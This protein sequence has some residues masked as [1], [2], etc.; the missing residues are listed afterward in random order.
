MKTY[1]QRRATVQQSIILASSTLIGG[2]FSTYFA[3]ATASRY[4]ET[5]NNLVD[6]PL[7]VGWG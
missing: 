2:R 6:P 7:M 3:G 5:S 4:E 1:N